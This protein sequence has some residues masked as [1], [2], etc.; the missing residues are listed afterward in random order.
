MAEQPVAAKTMGE[1]NGARHGENTRGDRFYRPHCDILERED[2]LLVLAD[3][4]G[5][6]GSEIDVKFEDGQLTIH[7]PVE[8][9]RSEEQEYVRQEYGVGDFHRTF[10]V[11]ES[12]DASKIAASY[13]DGVLTLRLPKAEAV[14]PRRIT[15]KAE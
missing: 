1:G 12:I 15:V 8:A 2:E 11:S 9:R 7:A 6:K 10:E 3:V 4:P 5:A 14:K 13:A